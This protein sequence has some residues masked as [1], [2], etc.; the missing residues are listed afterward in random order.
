L[1]R[2]GAGSIGQAEIKLDDG[3]GPWPA[4]RR[5]G[6]GRG[7]GWMKGPPKEI[8]KKRE[9]EGGG[10]AALGWICGRA[11]SRAFQSN[12]AERLQGAG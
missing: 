5:E 3:R 11:T 10:Q 12:S 2:G 1:G 7:R 9:R 8:S 6:R 4:G